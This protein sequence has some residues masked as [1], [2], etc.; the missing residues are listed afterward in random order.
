MYRRLDVHLCRRDR[1][2]PESCHVDPGG[3]LG[4][5]HAEPDARG[6]SAAGDCEIPAGFECGVVVAGRYCG[7]DLRAIVDPVVYWDS[8]DRI[9]LRSDLPDDI[10]DCG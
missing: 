3:V 8:L 7:S 1:T 4:C 6:K 2:F 5:A 10:G 9:V